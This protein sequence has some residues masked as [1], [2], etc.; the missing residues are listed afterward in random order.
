MTRLFSAACTPLASKL[1]I[2]ADKAKLDRDAPV[3]G[4]PHPSATGPPA[5]N[6]GRGWKKELAC[7]DVPDI[8]DS[9]C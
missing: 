9:I 7:Q 1:A 2:L 4:T 8:P 6:A 5:T 3:A